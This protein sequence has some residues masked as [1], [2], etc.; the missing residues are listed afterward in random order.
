MIKLCAVG[1][2]G[3]F[4]IV[5]AYQEETPGCDDF[6]ITENFHE[7]PY[8][9]GILTTNGEYIPGIPKFDNFYSN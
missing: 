3:L 4:F 2:V 5:N 7:L 8:D 1:L 9:G 6:S